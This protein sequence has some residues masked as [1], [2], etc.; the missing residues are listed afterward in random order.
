MIITS[1]L[2]LSF[3][4]LYVKLN[5]WNWLLQVW[6]NIREKCTPPFFW[7]LGLPSDISLFPHSLPIFLLLFT[8]G[9]YLSKTGNGV[10]DI[11]E[12]HLSCKNNTTEL[13]LVS[14]YVLVL[15][16]ASIFPQLLGFTPGMALRGVVA[17]VTKALV[18]LVAV[19]KW[20]SEVKNLCPFWSEPRLAPAPPKDCSQRVIWLMWKEVSV[21]F[22]W[23]EW[24]QQSP[25][26]VQTAH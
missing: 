26:S 18:E 1:C 16:E 9:I 13:C 17:W 22:F 10:Q 20:N 19:G 23:A 2:S 8:N 7:K 24:G 4:L 12:G 11:W 25:Q 15:A 21:D 14:L 6:P 3:Y 5:F